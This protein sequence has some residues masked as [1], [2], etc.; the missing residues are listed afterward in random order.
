MNAAVSFDP[1]RWEEI[2]RDMLDNLDRLG[3]GF[4][5]V[6]ERLF[7]AHDH[8]VSSTSY[9]PYNIIRDD[10]KYRIEIA[11]A[12]FKKED[13]D[14]SLTKN[15]L[16]ISGHT[17]KAEADKNIAYRGIATRKFKRSFALSDNTEV[18]VAKM[19]DGMLT[20]TIEKVVPEEE[21]EVS[22]QID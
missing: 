18:K 3:F 10:S 7:Q 21:K 17:P 2:P 19:E 1:Y 4:D 13:I 11:L 8:F 14:V 9:P 15:V 5:D 20:I 12:G 6:L 16:T 22:I